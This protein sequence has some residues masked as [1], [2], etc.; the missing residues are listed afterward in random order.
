MVKKAPEVLAWLV[1]HMKRRRQASLRKKKASERVSRP[2]FYIVSCSS[3]GSL[4]FSSICRC[5]EGYGT[6]PECMASSCD[7]LNSRVRQQ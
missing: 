4:K 6:R 5:A 1:T 2:A 3:Y 7:Q